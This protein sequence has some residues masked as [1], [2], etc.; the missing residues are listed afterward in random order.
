MDFVLNPDTLSKAREALDRSLRAPLNTDEN[1]TFK[2]GAEPG[3]GTW[4]EA[5]IIKDTSWAPP[6]NPKPGVSAQVAM[7]TLEVLGQADGG[8]ATNAGA[9]HNHVAYLDMG[10]LR[11]PGDRMHGLNYRRIGVLDQLLTAC[12]IDT[13]ANVSLEE[14]LSADSHG[15]KGLVGLR[16]GGV[17]RKYKYTKDRGKPTQEVVTAC[18]IDSFCVLPS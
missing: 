13:S 10:A 12:G 6:K 11:D 7:I 8:F 17:V 18:E 5:F 3:L 2:A 15:V 9:I 14:T 1:P 16:V 4:M